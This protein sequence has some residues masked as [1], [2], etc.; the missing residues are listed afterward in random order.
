[1]AKCLILCGGANSRW[2]GHLGIARKHLIEVE[3]ERLLQRCLRQV[4]SLGVRPIVVLNAGDIGLYCRHLS[5]DF[6][7]MEID[8]QPSGATEA[9]KSLSSQSAWHASCPTIVLL[10]DVWFSELAIGRIFAPGPAAWTVFGRAGASA[11]TGHPHGEI[12][13][14]RFA[15]SERHLEQLLKLDQLYRAG[16]C[17]RSAGWAHYHLMIGADPSMQ[18]AGRNFIQIDD[19]T[20]DFDT[21]RDYEAWHAGRRRWRALHGAGVEPAMCGPSPNF[22]RPRATA[23]SVAS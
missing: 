9:W 15:R 14:Q 4:R 5:G 2:N 22:G 23:V 7:I 12:F 21:P 19:F 3:G 8:P 6:E 17:S 16:R 1:M 13:A 18:C 10:G 11:L 20:D